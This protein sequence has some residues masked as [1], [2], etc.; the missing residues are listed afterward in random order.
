[1]DQE[2]LRARR[3]SADID[4]RELAALG[5]VL[6]QQGESS[7]KVRQDLAFLLL[8]PNLKIIEQTMRGLSPLTP[9]L[10]RDSVEYRL[11]NAIERP[12]VGPLTSRS[13]GLMDL[14]RLSTSSPVSWAIGSLAQPFRWALSNANRDMERFMEFDDEILSPHS[15]GI[16]IAPS[17][18]CELE[19][20]IEEDGNLEDAIQGRRGSGRVA[21]GARLL[22]KLFTIPPVS[23]PLS[24]A[25]R[26]ALLALIEHDSQPL[27]DSLIE[28]SETEPSGR[29]HVMSGL[30]A[31]FDRDDASALLERAPRV[32]DVVA[33]SALAQR[34]RPSI[35]EIQSLKIAVASTSSHEGWPAVAKTLVDAWLFEFYADRH[36]Y[37]TTDSAPISYTA[38]CWQVLANHVLNH[39]KKPLGLEHRT[40]ADV[41]QLLRS[42]LHWSTSGELSD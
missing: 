1:M 27:R 7:L 26:E 14:Q 21:A 10:I 17:P 41:D 20:L 9:S 13:A 28:A 35:S 12:L 19:V 29:H 2:S 40:P 4:A 36:E 3:D 34:P 30:W 42:T 5:A 22:H 39:P 18:E 15:P 37:D 16:D 11:I 31:Q 33:L 38:D 6:E 25:D 32:V 8:D 24:R 23:A